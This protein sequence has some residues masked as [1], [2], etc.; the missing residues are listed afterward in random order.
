MEKLTERNR[1]TKIEFVRLA[2]VASVGFSLCFVANAFAQN[3]PAAPAP[4]QPTAAEATAE[5][6]IVT[7]SNIP[8]AE[9]TGPNPVDTYR[10][11][12]IQ[13]MGVRSTQDLTTFL[14][15]ESGF[16]T[17]QN[18][19]NGGDGTIQLNLRGLLP[20]E[21]LVLVD[22]KRVAQSSLGASGFSAGVDINL[23][24]FPMIDHLDILK[25]GASAIYG[26]DAIAGVA[27]FILVHKFRGLE[28]GGSYGNT[29]MGASNDMGEWEAWI[30]AGTGDDKTDIVVI[31]DF[32]ER[33]GGL[34]SR[35]RNLSANGDQT[36]FGGFDGRSSNF[37][38][39]IQ[40]PGGS[41][42]SSF[43]L[44]PSFFFGPAGQSVNADG[45][46][47]LAVTP[48]PHSAAN[49]TTDPQYI[50]PKALGLNG[51]GGNNLDHNLGI[52]PTGQSR[53]SGAQ[54]RDGDYVAFNFAAFT[55]ALPP[56]DRQ[57]FYG[58]FSRDLCDKYL[59]V[60]TDF[61]YTRSFFDA[62]LAAVPF[63]PDAF[64]NPGAAVGLSGASN[65]IS[66]PLS[67]PFNPFTVADDTWI[68]PDGTAV[69]VTTGVKFRGINDT[70]PRSEKF[71]YWDSLFDVGLKGEMGEFG[72][73]FKTWNWEVGF[74]Y[75]RNE[76]Q[77]LSVGEVS[78]PGLREALLDTNP[79]TAFDPF[80][81][82]NAHNTSAAKSRVYVNLHNSGEFELPL[83]YATLNGDLFNLPAG[84]VSFAVGGEYHG[85][86][87]TRDRDALN[88]TFS[89]IGSVD[90]QSFKNNRDV[91][92][93]YQEVRIPVASPTWNFPGAYSLE[94]D[95]AEREE[96]Y[97]QNT[98]AVPAFLAPAQPSTST[99]FN[100]QRPKFSV[101]WEPLD[102]KY[103]GA[104]T[105][106]GSYSEGFHAPTLAELSPAASENF[107]AVTDP[108]ST[109]TDIQIEERVLGNPKLQPEVAYEWTYGLVY[110][111][112]WLKGLTM[113]A[114]WWHIDMRSIVTALGSQFIIATNPP[115]PSSVNPTGVQN[116]PLVFR[117]PTS[118][119]GEAGPINLII[120]P[121]SN[122]AGAIFEGLD[123]EFIYI[124][125]TTNFGGPDI[126]RFTYTVNGTWVSRAELQ[127][128]PDSKM[129]G[130]NGEFLPSAF[131]LTNSLPRNRA[132]LSLFYDGPANTW[133]AGF[134]V[135]AIVHWTS[136]YND[137]NIEL[138]GG[139]PQTP[140]IIP[141]GGS[142]SQ[143]NQIFGPGQQSPAARKVREWTTLDL[144]ASYTFNLPAPTAQQEVPGYA[145]DGGKNVKMKD[146]KEKNVMP[147]STAAYNECGWRAWLNGLTLTAGLQNVFDT[148]PPFVA[149]NFENG[150]DESL[151]TIKGRF[152]YA[153]L[154]KRF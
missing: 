125:D 38:G 9:E 99:Q 143:G 16:T 45:T 61:K 55:P 76:G 89:T 54:F 131:S 145:K 57:S 121:S 113:S 116:G 52:L 101:R 29:N 85:E 7:G 108:F 33:T 47:N 41:S 132:N 137:D 69:P 73:Y 20:K 22:G 43:R 102:P 3:P 109:Q 80:L 134:D 78:Q 28:I 71:T 118:V 152:W 25:D 87:F 94:F 51:S 88:T 92:S 49:V 75:S 136:Q 153:Q 59:T 140:S 119:P 64:K 62:S 46:I 98:S 107:P 103:I 24:P 32:F 21:T 142:Y 11:E 53:K 56:A 67:N 42:R 48:L 104:V 66:V 50:K 39:R 8:T 81:N 122:L 40:G 138:A 4:A 10:V 13:K 91:W 60:F 100:T 151:A 30:K 37:P 68:S 96:W 77:D 79:L 72:D 149:G 19:G 141:A 15:Q 70:G 83:A 133:M 6:V 148:D 14:P 123:Y 146:G 44:I 5:R 74:R 93:M 112:K 150:Y 127:T 2:F 27:N 82:F 65:G 114:D 111:P 129:F 90:G 139:K 58:S 154:K 128:S 34:F 26:A 110:S 17:N 1:R 84:P 126:G 86:R 35:D 97:S 124:L 130:I 120:D 18:I 12:D 147:V 105:L 117:T 106:R 31:A 115:A 36:A 144:I 63:T 23:I 135:G 95:I